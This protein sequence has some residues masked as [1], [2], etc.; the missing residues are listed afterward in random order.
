[1][2]EEVKPIEQWSRARGMEISQYQLLGEGDYAN[3][4]WESLY[5]GHI[6]ALYHTAA[7]NAWDRIEEVRKNIEPFV[8]VIQ[9]SKETITDFS[10]RMTSGVN[11]MIPNSKARQIIIE[12]LTFENASSQCKR[13]IRPL[14]ERSVPLQE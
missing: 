12:S 7:L 5:H 8:K 1:M 14:K 2:K 9:D 3:I 11:R 13:I 10:Q 6:L 4:K